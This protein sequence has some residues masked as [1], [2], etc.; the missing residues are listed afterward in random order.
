MSCA[1]PQASSWQSSLKMEWF[2]S[3]HCQRGDSASALTILAVN[4]FLERLNLSALS[5]ATGPHKSA[6]TCSLQM[7][8]ATLLNKF[9]GRYIFLNTK[10]INSQRFGDFD[11]VRKN[12][13]AKTYPK[14]SWSVKINHRML[15][16]Q[17]WNFKK[18]YK[19]ENQ[20]NGVELQ[21]RL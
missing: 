14:T 2:I 7:E 17:K 5:K 8:K 3:N 12:I 20:S 15:S 10:N 13:R 16:V 11:T 6:Q 19:N 21:L 18:G 9:R 4:K 1:E